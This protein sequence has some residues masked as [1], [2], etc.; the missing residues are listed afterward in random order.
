MELHPEELEATG[1]LKLIGGKIVAS[2][3]PTCG[4]R[5]LD[6]FVVSETLEHAAEVACAIND[7][8]FKPHSP[9]RLYIEANARHAVV[10]ELKVP[11]GFG[12]ILPHGPDAKPTVTDRALIGPDSELATD[13]SDYVGLIRQIE[14]E[15]CA[16]DKPRRKRGGTA[17]RS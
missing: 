6:F 10:R 16:V 12:A 8:S 14:A 4:D 2:G 15:L 7:A 9:V 11:K 13:G 17:V 3:K 1:W 5:E